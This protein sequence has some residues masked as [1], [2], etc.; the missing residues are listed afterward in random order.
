[1]GVEPE[2]G[3]SA[4]IHAWIFGSDP[5]PQQGS[6][7]PNLSRSMRSGS[8]LN[9]LYPDPDLYQEVTG[10]ICLKNKKVHR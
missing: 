6:I 4:S 5:G 2:L 7:D 8:T 1:M 3:S 10:N 9:G